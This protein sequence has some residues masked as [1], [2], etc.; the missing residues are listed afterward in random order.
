MITLVD[1]HEVVD[2][3]FLGEFFNGLGQHATKKVLIGGVLVGSVAA[4]KGATGF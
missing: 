3:S 4:W 2:F 1:G